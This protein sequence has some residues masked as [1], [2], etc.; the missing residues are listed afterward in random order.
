MSKLKCLTIKEKN[1]TPHEVSKG[2]KKKDIALNLVF[3][4]T[5]GQQKSKPLVIGRST[6]PGC[7]KG[8]KSLGVDYDF[9][10]KSWITSEICEK[11]IQK[12][13]KRMIA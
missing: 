12:L 10:K 6:N 13:D 8:A 2:V 9:N 7:F 3:L 11:W 5:A 1:L 4:Q